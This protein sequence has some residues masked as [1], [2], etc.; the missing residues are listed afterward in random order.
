[1]P[2]EGGILRVDMYLDNSD[3]PTLEMRPYKISPQKISD[4]QLSV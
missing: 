1:M 3:Q 4:A 2:E